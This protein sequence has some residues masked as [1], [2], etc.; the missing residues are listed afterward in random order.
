MTALKPTRRIIYT[1]D[2]STGKPV[3]SS[4]EVVMKQTPFGHSVGLS[5]SQSVPAKLSDA[6]DGIKQDIPWWPGE[7]G[8]TSIVCGMSVVSARF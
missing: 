4:S 6:A 1:T 5:F 8:M 2:T 3:V 7:H